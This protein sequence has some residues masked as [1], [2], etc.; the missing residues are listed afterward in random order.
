MKLAI[1]PLRDVCGVNDFIYGTQIEATKGDAFDFYFQLVD[2]EKNLGQ[3]AY[4]PPGLRVIPG[5]GSMV[6]LNI[7]NCDKAKRFARQATNPFP[8]DT[9]IWKITLLDTDPLDCSVNFKVVLLDSI[10]NPPTQRTCHV[11]GA[12]VLR[13]G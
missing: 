13:N 4:S 12:L 3:H 9:S 1:R 7:W 10:T 8:Q 2:L 6:T 11:Q 5:D